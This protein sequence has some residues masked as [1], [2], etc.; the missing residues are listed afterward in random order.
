MKFDYSTPAQ[1]IAELRR[2]FKKSSGMQTLRIAR[3]IY[4]NLTVAQ[5][6]SAFNLSDAQVNA[7]R[8]RLLAM[9]DQLRAVE[10]ARGE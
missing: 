4:T 6:K 7:L 1:N 9:W 8:T 5:I 10:D 2:R 3:W